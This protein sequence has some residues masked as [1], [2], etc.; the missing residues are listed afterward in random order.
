[1]TSPL[2]RPRIDQGGISGLG[3][4]SNAEGPLNIIIRYSAGK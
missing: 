4:L 2:L 3:H 1:V